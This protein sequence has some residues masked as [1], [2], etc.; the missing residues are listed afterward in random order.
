MAIFKNKVFLLLFKLVAILL[1][2]LIVLLMISHLLLSDEQKFGPT[3][4]SVIQRKYDKIC[5]Q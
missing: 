5:L 1:V 3:Y 4:Q 2:G